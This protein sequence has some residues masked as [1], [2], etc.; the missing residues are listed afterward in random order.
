MRKA[1]SAGATRTFL[2]R[3]MCDSVTVQ[4]GLL[5]YNVLPFRSVVPYQGAPFEF[6]PATLP[7]QSTPLSAAPR[8]TPKP[9]VLANPPSVALGPFPPPLTTAV[10]PPMVLQQYP[11]TQP[12]TASQTVSGSPSH[13]LARIIPIE[14]SATK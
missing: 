14:G 13:F 11:I 3:S 8:F 7:R 2:Y 6:A 1:S 10:R 4:F 9:I 12:S 5:P